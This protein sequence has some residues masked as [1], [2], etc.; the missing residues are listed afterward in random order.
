MPPLLECVPNVSEGRDAAVV[1][2]LAEAVRGGGAE[3]LDVHSDVDHHRSV[4]T[5]VGATAI[6]ERSLLAL[7]R[8][9]VALIDLRHHRGAHPRI[10]ALDVA[11]FVPLRGASMADAV[12]SAHRAGHAV[13]EACGVPV[14][15]YGEAALRSDRRELPA[16]RRGGF[17]GLAQRMAPPE[18]R[19]DAGPPVPHPTAGATAVGARRLLIALNA[20]LASADVAVAAAIAR[21][22]RE[23]T[24]GG[25][26]GVRALGLFLA[27]RGVAQ[28]SM[29]L[30][31]PWRSPPVMVAERVE[32]EAR[33]RGVIVREYELVG[34]APASLFAEWPASRAPLAGITA[35]QLLTPSLFDATP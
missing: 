26:P 14:F 3:L 17:E 15:F 24:P 9:A 25:L 7:A 12:A 19:P 11:P 32:R 4:L 6:V 20:D 18:G 28:V 21:A 34:C 5:F 27:S 30:I 2:A 16:V 10:G 13:A 8:A 33:A 31:D 35:S 29:N 23:A 22:V 1:A